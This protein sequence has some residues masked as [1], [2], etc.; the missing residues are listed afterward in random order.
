MKSETGKGT[1]AWNRYKLEE[2]VHIKL[3]LFLKFASVELS[4]KLF[5]I[6]IDDSLILMF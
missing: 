3:N 5:K 4:K 2:I 1:Q 6:C